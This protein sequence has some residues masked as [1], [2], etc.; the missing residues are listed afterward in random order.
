MRIQ[1]RGDTRTVGSGL[2]VRLALRQTQQIAKPPLLPLV[3]PSR[4]T[5]YGRKVPMKRPAPLVSPRVND[6]YAVSAFSD[7][8]DPCEMLTIYGTHCPSVIDSWL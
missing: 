2:F 4:I 3:G 1:H 7:L 5:I 6:L 8:G